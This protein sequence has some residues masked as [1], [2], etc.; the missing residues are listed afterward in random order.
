MRRGT[1]LL[2]TALVLLIV[3]IVTAMALPAF[4]ALRDRLAADAAAQLLAAAHGRAR[5]IATAEGRTVLLAL[6]AD[7]VTIRVVEPPDDTVERWRGPGPASHGA[8]V[9][10][11]PRQVVFG[12]HGLPL[13]AANA[14]Y[15]ATRGAGRRQ[16]VVSRYGRLRVF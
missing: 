8:A 10:G 5:M 12:A 14:T 4:A 3:G 7:S 1:T 13:G 15:V 6:A 11:L 16:V 9:T 2:E